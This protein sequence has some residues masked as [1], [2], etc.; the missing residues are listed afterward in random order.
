MNDDEVICNL[1][2]L[3]RIIRCGFESCPKF[4][5]DGSNFGFYR[6]VPPLGSKQANANVWVCEEHLDFM[7]KF[8]GVPP[9]SQTH[10]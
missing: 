8:F 1:G 7:N 10:A 2:C 9:M 5:A 6:M 4:C 3:H